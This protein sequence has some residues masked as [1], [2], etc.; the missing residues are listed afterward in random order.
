MKQRTKEIAEEK[1]KIKQIPLTLD[2]ALHYQ[3]LTC[4][5]VYGFSCGIIL[6]ANAQCAHITPNIPIVRMA[7]IAR[8]SRDSSEFWLSV[9]SLY[10]FLGSEKHSSK[11]VTITL[12]R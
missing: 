4:S 2:D 12:N 5:M 8:K 10:Q 6:F 11:V 1:G 9:V 3:L 7:F